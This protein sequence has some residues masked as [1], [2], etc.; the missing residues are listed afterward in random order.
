MQ[1]DNFQSGDELKE[2]RMNKS[3]IDLKLTDKTAVFDE[4]GSVI[5]QIVY[6]GSPILSTVALSNTLPLLKSPLGNKG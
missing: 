1:L 5:I 6:G 4:C 3:T 2:L